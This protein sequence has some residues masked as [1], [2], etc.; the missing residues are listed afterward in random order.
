MFRLTTATS[1]LMVL[2]A[3]LVALVSARP[4]A[5][6]W[7]D[8][9]RLATVECLV[10]YHT[11]AVDRSIFLHPGLVGPTGPAPYPRD[12]TLLMKS[13]T[14]D[15]LLIQGQYYSDKSPVPALLMAG[16]Y[17]AIQQTT[18]LTAR[19]KPDWFCYLMTVFSSG[20]GYI[21][22]VTSMHLLSRRHLGPGARALLLTA[23]FAVGTVALTYARQV[24]N[25]VML[26]GD[27][28]L[29]LVGFQALADRQD[30]RQ[31]PW[32]LLA[33]LGAVSGLGYGIDLGVGPILLVSSFALVVYRR[34]NAAQAAVFLAGALPWVIAHHVMNYRIGGTFLPA[35][36]VTAF[37][38]W[39]GSP[40][41][42]GEITGTFG[43][44]S[45]GHVLSYAVQLLVGKKG[46]LL[47]NPPLLMAVMA[48]PVLLRRRPHRL[49]EHPELLFAAAVS[50]GT[51]AVYS[52]MS[53]NYSGVCASI[54]WFVPLLAPAFYILAVHLRESPASWPSFVVLA[55][56]GV[57]LAL[58][59]WWKGP[60]M[61]RMMPTV[62]FY[63]LWVCT[64]LPSWAVAPK[65]SGSSDVI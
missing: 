53:T 17:L 21:V 40:F 24:N 44:E 34:P 9:S 48:L 32:A 25:H 58:V 31:V 7:N 43:H 8:G 18:G 6:G 33:G 65:R 26:L 22:A 39:P 10:D 49:K 56:F 57:V 12:Y 51:W 41:G 16:V 36:T 20:I 27:V 63:W 47:Y 14:Q 60:W 61:E 35:N 45:P 3:L 15:K 62:P 54:R 5:G 55:C 52:V 11:L 30:G 2:G 4:Y 37:L 59:M 46:F 29:L 19:A 23:S 28:A 13:G 42:A 1:S 38:S 64:A 50:I